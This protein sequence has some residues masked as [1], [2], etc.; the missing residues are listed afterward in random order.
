MATLWVWATWAPFTSETLCTSCPALRLAPGSSVHSSQRALSK[1]TPDRAAARKTPPAPAIG[2][3]Q[4]QWLSPPCSLPS[5]LVTLLAGQLC[6]AAPRLW[7]P[8]LPRGHSWPPGSLSSSL[9]T[10]EV[11]PQPVCFT[12]L[13]AIPSPRNFASR[14]LSDV[15]VWRCL[16]PRGWDFFDT[17]NTCCSYPSLSAILA[18]SMRWLN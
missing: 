13:S 1:R 12:I 9:H 10:L 8:F 2:P 11:T 14:F 18:E 6:R 15:L 4:R 16:S 5:S 17:R 7:T 3:T